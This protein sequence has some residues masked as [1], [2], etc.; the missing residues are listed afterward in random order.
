MTRLIAAIGFVLALLLPSSEEARAEG[1][2]IQSMYENCTD[3]EGKMALCDGYISGVGDM[4]DAN[5]K[6]H[7]PGFSMCGS[8]SYGAMIQAFKNWA[9]QHP[10]LWSKPQ[11][12]GVAAALMV[13]WPCLPTSPK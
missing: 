4:M 8:P 11:L 3:T 13:T 2:T 12:F 7:A 9:P 5:G 6:L 1:G 10:E